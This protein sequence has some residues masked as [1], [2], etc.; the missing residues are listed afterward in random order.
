MALADVYESYRWFDL[1]ELAYL[2]GLINKA[3]PFDRLTDCYN[4]FSMKST[5]SSSVNQSISI[6]EK[7]SLSY[8][9]RMAREI[10][11]TPTV[12]PQTTPIIQ[13]T[14]SRINMS[15]YKNTPEIEKLYHSPNDAKL[16][17]HT[18]GLINGRLPLSSI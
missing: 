3:E 1:A 2:K 18:P 11:I 13:K 17:P 6:E 9:R 16:V 8:F 14:Q 5:E 7:R 15:A 12:S 4:R 10:T